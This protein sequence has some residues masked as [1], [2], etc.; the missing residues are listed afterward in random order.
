MNEKKLQREIQ[1]RVEKK[2]FPLFEEYLL[3]SGELAMVLKWKP[4]VLLLGNYS[5]GKSTL[6]NEL[7]D[8]EIQLT[9]QAPT[10]DSFT[11]ITAPGVNEKLGLVTGASLVNDDQL[12]FSRLKAYGEKLSSHFQMK[13]IDFPLL[14]NLAIIDTPGMLDSVTEK[15]RGYDFE[16]VIGEFALLAD[17]VVLMF[18]PHKA[19]TIKETYTTIR[20]TL[21][22]TSEEDRVV[23]VMS[24]IDECDN[25]G[26]LIRSYGTLCWNL[27]QMTGRKDIPRIF[28]TFSPTVRRKTKALEAWV[29]ERNQLKEKILAAPGHKISHILH[30]LDRKLHELKLTAEAMVEFVKGGRCALRGVVKKAV[31]GGIG[32]FITIDL[33]SA[34]VTGSGGRSFLLSLLAGAV[35]IDKLVLPLFGVLITWS[36]SALW[37]TKWRLPRYF[38][39]CREDVDRLVSLTTPYQEYIWQRVRGN[40]LALISAPELDMKALSHPHQK[41]LERVD[42]FIRED[43]KR[44]FSMDRLIVAEGDEPG[45]QISLDSPYDEPTVAPDELSRPVV[46]SESL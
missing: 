40:V 10:D 4:I 5:S 18:D 33:F 22:E 41:N 11:V 9:G 38:Q 46:K 7:L 21:P 36:A 29:D 15:G 16:K 24:R 26:D 30:L 20:G 8:A 3:D 27:S 45:V 28:L 42:R 31:I 43:L 39:A 25:L 34:M 23:Y 1:A 6:I 35:A 12:P 44:Y 2:L 37:F 17:L 13:L 32:V 14:E 19:G